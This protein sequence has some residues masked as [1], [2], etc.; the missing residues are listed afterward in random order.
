MDPSCF[1]HYL[2]WTFCASKPWVWQNLHGWSWGLFSW[3]LSNPR[4]WVL[5]YSFSFVNI[6]WMRVSIVIN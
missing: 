4:G 6:W 1:I 3:I 5:R 2:F